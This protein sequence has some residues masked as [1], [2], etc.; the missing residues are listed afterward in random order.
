MYIH[1]TGLIAHKTSKAIT[2]LLNPLVGTRAYHVKNTT[3]FGKAIKNLQIG[4][5]E[6]MN[7]HDVVSLFTN[8]SIP[9][10]M[11][12]IREGLI[13]DKTLSERTNLHAVDIMS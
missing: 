10:V 1:Y 3:E 4:E 2:D 9:E 5:E 7:V 13:K 8:V 6:I 11:D 12:L